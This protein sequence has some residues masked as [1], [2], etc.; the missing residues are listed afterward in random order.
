M[1]P[2]RI[3]IA[4]A[5]D[6]PGDDD[7]ARYLVDRMWPRGVT[8][9][10]LRIEAWLREVAPSTELRRWF[11]HDPERWDAFIERYRAELDDNVEAWQPLAEAARHG[12]LTLVYGARDREHNQAVALRDYLQE[13][14]AHR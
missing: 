12:R 4:R 11:G 8:K 14:L 5:Y 2:I 9:E 6:P 10:S 7:G 3:D 1:K 13:K